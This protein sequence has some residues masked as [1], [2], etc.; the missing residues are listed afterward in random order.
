MA[1]RRAGPGVA[2]PAP[3]IDVALVSYTLPLRKPNPLTPASTASHH[4][5]SSTEGIYK[6]PWPWGRGG[7]GGGGGPPPPPPPPP[8]AGGGGGGRWRARPPRPPAKGSLVTLTRAT[9]A[10]AFYRCH[11]MAD[12]RHCFYPTVGD[13]PLLGRNSY[14]ARRQRGGLIVNT[15]LSGTAQ[16]VGD[17]PLLGKSNRQARRPSGTRHFI[18]RPFFHV[19]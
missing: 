14:H 7:G 11:P 12:C 9:I 8:P 10:F 2:R 16:T 5:Q 4:V 19:S 13:M 18:T 6:E 15:T 3:K 17:M 1:R